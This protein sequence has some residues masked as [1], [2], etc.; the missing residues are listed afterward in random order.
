MLATVYKTQGVVS[1]HE[2]VADPGGLSC[3]STLDWSHQVS[4]QDTTRFRESW[5]DAE[6]VDLLSQF[7]LGCSPAL[8]ELQT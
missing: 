6:R 5:R 1:P 4:R 7:T 3:V 2:N 8:F